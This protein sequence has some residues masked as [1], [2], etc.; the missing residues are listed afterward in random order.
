MWWL[1]TNVVKTNILSIKEKLQYMN[2]VS[3]CIKSYDAAIKYEL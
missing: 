3:D 1:L 2:K